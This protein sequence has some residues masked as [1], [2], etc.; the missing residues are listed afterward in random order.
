[1]SIA[2]LLNIQQIAS[3]KIPLHDDIPTPAIRAE[4]PELQRGLVWNPLQ[5][6]LLWDSLLR[7]FPIGSLVVCRVR[8]P[9]LDEVVNITHDLLDGQQR[10]QAITL[11]YEDPFEKRSNAESILWIDLNASNSGSRKF[12]FRVTT[13]AQP[14][15]YRRRDDKLERLSL[16]QIRDALISSGFM[17]QERRPTQFDETGHRLWPR[18]DQCWPHDATVPIPFSWVIASSRYNVATPQLLRDELRMELSAHNRSDAPQWINTAINYLESDASITNLEGIVEG[19]LRAKQTQVPCLDVSNHIFQSPDNQQFEVPI[20]DIEH[21]FARINNGGT[22]IDSDDLQ[23]SMIKAYWPG[24]KPEINS[25]EPRRVPE[26]RLVGLGARLAL[27][28]VL[29][30]QGPSPLSS[31]IGIRELRRFATEADDGPHR[32]PLSQ[33]LTA[34][35]KKPALIRLVIEKVQHWISWNAQNRTYGLPPVLVTSIARTSEEV[36][37]LLMWLAERCLA[38]GQEIDSDDW[39]KRVIGLATTLHWLSSQK[40]LAVSAI[41]GEIAKRLREQVPLNDR[42]FDNVLQCALVQDDKGR[43][44]LTS[45]LTEDAF[46]AELSIP[47]AEELNMWRWWKLPPSGR[48]DCIMKVKS[49]K[50]L[51]LYAQREYIGR[52]FPKYDPARQDSWDVADRPWDFD[53]ILPRAGIDYQ[54]VGDHKDALKD[55]VIEGNCIA[56]LRAWWKEQNRSD[57]AILPEEKIKSSDTLLDSFIKPEE[58]AAFNYCSSNPRDIRIVI[59]YITASKKRLARIYGEWYNSLDIERLYNR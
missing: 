28:S 18:P 38:N 4:P 53:H 3:W 35:N 57:Q 9:A 2:H 7:G 10:A 37:L 22:R 33:M 17:D 54:N 30:A 36:F 55:W 23:Y 58:L 14:W 48:L 50:E 40:N 43:T 45:P 26:A 46:F 42:L 47:N 1:M 15:G 6:E 52:E 11:G 27:S 29:P 51:L 41:A 32:L 39:C 16:P 59:S 13:T 12:L 25:I 20:D 56:N 24:V 8:I 19:V 49:N 21:L 5:I 34:V 44:P 31:A